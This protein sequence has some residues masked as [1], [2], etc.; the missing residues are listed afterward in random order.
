MRL[1]FIITLF[2]FI[3]NSQSKMFK[4]SEQLNSRKNFDSWKQF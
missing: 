2:T 1:S 4:K 3:I